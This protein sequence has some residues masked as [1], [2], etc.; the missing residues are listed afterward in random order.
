M[1]IIAG[2]ALKNMWVPLTAAERTD[3]KTSSEQEI[4][5]L[6]ALECFSLRH[7]E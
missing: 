1:I 7:C 6:A 4:S 2:V 3:G 5:A